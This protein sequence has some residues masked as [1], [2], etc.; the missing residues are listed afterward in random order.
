MSRV[1]SLLTSIHVFEVAARHVHFTR[2]AN[3]L[4]ITQAAV[5]HHISLLEK[6]L[7][8]RLFERRHR[9]LQLTTSG[10]R[11]LNSVQE[12][13]D[14]LNTATAD[15]TGTSTASRLA[16][17]GYSTFVMLWLLPRLPLFTKKHPDIHVDI[18]NSPIGMRFHR[19]DCDLMIRYGV[20]TRGDGDSYMLFRDVMAPVCNPSLLSQGQGEFLLDRYNLIHCSARPHDW[21]EWVSYAGINSRVNRGVTYGTSLLAFEGA[22][23]GIGL[24]IGQ[25]PILTSYFDAGTLVVAHDI[26]LQRS[27]GYYLTHSKMARK[28]SRIKAFTDWIL[29]EAGHKP[30]I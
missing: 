19:E 28:D 3:E 26:R 4:G 23:E 17:R 15:L 13:F 5:S 6:S 20:P 10:R 14:T 9:S 1:Q 25:L 8:V 22:K 29:E 27:D 24:A 2:A 7:G 11:Y 21:L 30:K 16:I 12:A 18:L